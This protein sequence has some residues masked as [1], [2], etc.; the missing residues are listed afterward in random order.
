MKLKF[1]KTIKISDTTFKVIKNPKDSGGEFRY[2]N[3]DDKKE[4][5]MGEITIGTL[6]LKSNPTRVL[7][8]IIHELKEIIQVEQGVRFRQDGDD[9]SQFHYTHKEHSDLCARLAGLLEE[10]LE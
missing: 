5:K 4:L 10:F 6:L 9:E 3:N 1:P 2:W 7:S 8:I